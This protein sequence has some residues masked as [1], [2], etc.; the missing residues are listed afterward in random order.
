[1]ARC[2]GSG[3][4]K[5]G[6]YASMYP[7]ED[8]NVHPSAIGRTMFVD[9]VDHARAETIVDWLS[10]SDAVVRVAQIR[11]LGGAA[12]RVPADATA[13]AHRTKPILVKE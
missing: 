6:P 13:F 4:V 8:P 3:E 2:A 12:A 9:S 7:P 5:P 11:V 1:M 10:K